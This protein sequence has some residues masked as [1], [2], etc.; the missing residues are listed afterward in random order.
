LGLLNTKY[1]LSPHEI[2][3]KN[4]LLVKKSN[5]ILIYQNQKFLPSA[6]LINDSETIPIKITSHSPNKI[7]L[8]TQ[9]LPSGKLVLS[10][11]FYPGWKAISDE[12][13]LNIYPEQKILRAV[14][15]K[16]GNSKIIFSYE[17]KPFKHG[18]FLSS[19]TLLS[20]IILWRINKSQTDKL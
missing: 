18:L 9:N 15:F 13:N 20:I 16:S 6:Y 17:P 11:I 4:F 10:E 14:N 5:D 19:V 2:T 3:A 1:V 8:D 12:G 7:I